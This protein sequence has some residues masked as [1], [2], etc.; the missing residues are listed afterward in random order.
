MPFTFPAAVNECFR[1]SMS[2]VP[3]VNSFLS[4]RLSKKYVVVS[5]WDL[6]LHFLFFFFNEH[7]LV[8]FSN[9]TNEGNRQML[10]VVQKRIGK[11]ATYL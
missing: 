9:S 10:Q 1:F 7:P 3:C 5:H 4:V 6:S 2:P 8:I 11:R